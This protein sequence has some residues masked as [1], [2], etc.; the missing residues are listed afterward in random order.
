[1]EAARH[2]AA[3]D[4]DDDHVLSAAD[5]AFLDYWAEVAVRLFLEQNR[6]QK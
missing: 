5:L 3:P 4:L 6:E 1:M 2:G